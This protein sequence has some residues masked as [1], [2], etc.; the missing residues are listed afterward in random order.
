MEGETLLAKPPFWSPQT[1]KGKRRRKREGSEVAR[2]I[3]M[4]IFSPPASSRRWRG[5]ERK[6]VQ[7]SPRKEIALPFPCTNDESGSPRKNM[8]PAYAFRWGRRSENFSGMRN[9]EFLTELLG[10]TFGYDLVLR[11]PDLSVVVAATSVL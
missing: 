9:S 11:R 3:A 6:Q 2:A 8:R 10:K 1:K 5:R 7:D 4:H